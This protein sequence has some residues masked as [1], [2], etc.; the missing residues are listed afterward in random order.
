[1]PFMCDV[2][3][4]RPRGQSDGGDHRQP[5]REERRKTGRSID[6]CGYD[7]GKKVKVKKRPRLLSTQCLLLC[8]IVHA[9]DIQDRVSSD[10]RNRPLV[11][12]HDEMLPNI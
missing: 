8:A 2:A 1:M 7:A 6:P 3:N 11:L 5:K 12:P 10:I 9:A 4:C